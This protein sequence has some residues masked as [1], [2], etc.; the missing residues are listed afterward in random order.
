M[1]ASI[2]AM[3]KLDFLVV[4][5]YFTDNMAARYADIVL[6]QIATAYEGRNCFSAIHSTDLFKSGT[7]HGNYFLY[8]QKCVE[9]PG[10]V[11]SGD[12]VWV[13]IARRLGLAGLYSPRLAGVSD[14]AWDETIEDFHREAYEKWASSKDIA[15]F[16]PPGWDEFQNRPVF[17]VEIKE[18]HYAFKEDIESGQ[19]PFRGTPSG[20]IEFYSQGLA[21][22]AAYLASTDF[23]PG[24]GKCYG[25][26]NLPPMAQMTRG[27]RDT[28]FSEDARKYPLLMSS[29]HS[30]Y[31]V[32]SFL[33]NN[34][35]LRGDCYR[36]AVWISIADAAARG[37]KDDDLVKVYNDIGE[38]VIPA[39]VTSR[40]VPG[41]VYVSHG[42]WY[43]PDAIK[44][45]L[46]PDGI[47]F[48]GSPNFLTH[49]ED[50]PQTI[51]GFLP[52][53]ALVEVAKWQ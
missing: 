34:R 2:R 9:P 53:K 35:L 18:P 46:M 37:I 10:E 43:R 15:P 52:C 45:D 25:G 38:M 30:P 33:D 11:K 39:Y 4:S 40:I 48:G 1:N 32:H 49:N 26:G 8:R 28:F 27:G 20:K 42:S 16:N 47:D 29:P 5:S 7:Y 12:W 24:Y 41:T 17:R 19:N 3:K 14:E 51:I 23:V 13:Q 31:R 6:P 36:H 44:S 50:L 22:G 21:R